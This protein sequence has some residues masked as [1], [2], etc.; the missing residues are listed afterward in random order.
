MSATE[1]NMSLVCDESFTYLYHNRWGPYCFN[2]GRMDSF[3]GYANY[4]GIETCFVTCYNDTNN[5]T[6]STCYDAYNLSW[7]CLDNLTND[8]DFL[9]DYPEDPGCYA[10]FDNDETTGLQCDDGLDNDG[11][12]LI[13]YNDTDCTNVFD[14][15]E[16]TPSSPP[17]NGDGGDDDGIV[18]IPS[19]DDDSDRV[20]DDV[21]ACPDTPPNSTLANYSVYN[22]FAGC[23]CEQIDALLWNN[24]CVDYNCSGNVLEVFYKEF[25]ETS[26][27][28]DYCVRDILFYHP[29]F[30][31]CVNGSMLPCEPV[32]IENITGCFNH[33]MVVAKDVNNK[34]VIIKPSFGDDSNV[35]Y[36]IPPL[37]GLPGF[38]ETLIGSSS[39]YYLYPKTVSVNE[40]FK[41][42]S[43]FADESFFADL[44]LYKGDKL[45]DG[46]FFCDG[47]VDGSKIFCH[48][49]WDAVVY[50][51]GT[52]EF[53]FVVD[54]YSGE[55]SV[56][57]VLF[58]VEV[59]D[60]SSPDVVSRV[61]VG[62]VKKLAPLEKEIVADIFRKMIEKGLRDE[63]DL[64]EEYRRV[65]EI[66]NF[67]EVSKERVIRDGRTYFNIVIKPLRG[68]KLTNLT[69][70]EFIPKEVAE[71][72]DE[73][74]FNIQPIII[75]P[76]PLI[77]WHF[78]EVSERIDL[79]Y[80]VGKEVH[81]NGHTVLTAGEIVRR[82][83][84]W[85]SWLPA[86]LIPIV[87][88][89]FIRLERYFRRGPKLRD[90]GKKHPHKKAPK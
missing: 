90:S 13:D 72:V 48:N 30:G 71:S 79:S 38:G 9:I 64:E 74:N 66:N 53:K 46:D 73:I 22:E 69:V 47:V 83:P 25:Y 67:V 61:V 43:T 39:F 24:S 65:E 19:G 17:G 87:I 4:T 42:R 56:H 81:V 62:D 76:D 80:D 6:N 75:E 84:S 86:L 88:I 26:C 59:V 50:E 52:Y 11:D 32:A 55:P 85:I 60:E 82:T 8:N 49:D 34:M 12:G 44:K 14:D 15:D 57:E 7:A 77:M 10:P 78:E 45:L 20:A 18:I 31:T 3:C 36:M 2:P 63:V 89:F 1:I 5:I 68:K 35:K 51:P 29:A 58:N 37:L 33:E 28:E 40:F 27:P 70:F 16:S 41:I 54:Y 21:D 23:T